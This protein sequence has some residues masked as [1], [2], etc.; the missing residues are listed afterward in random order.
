YAVQFMVGAKDANGIVQNE[1]P[2]DLIFQSANPSP[3]NTATLTINPPDLIKSVA[4]GSQLQF[5]VQSALSGT[6]ASTYTATINKTPLPSQPAVGQTGA[7]T[8]TQNP[9]TGA[10]PCTET[11]SWTPNLQ[12]TANAVCFQAIYTSASSF[13]QS[14]QQ[15]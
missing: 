3:L 13:V 12:S 1:V 6:N 2:L 15:C 4:V 7:A 8:F 10:A 11:F 14:A 5:T 9:C